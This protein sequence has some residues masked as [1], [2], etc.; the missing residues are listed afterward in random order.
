MTTNTSGCTTKA[1]MHIPSFHLNNHGCSD[2]HVIIH[3]IPST[4]W[5]VFGAKIDKSVMYVSLRTKEAACE[6]P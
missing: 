1:P 2:A 4:R 6:L 5:L 3:I